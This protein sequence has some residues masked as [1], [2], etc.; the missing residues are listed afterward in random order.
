MSA[1]LYIH[2]PFCAG[3]CSYCSFNSV[4]AE[5]NSPLIKGYFEA[6]A[7]EI[8]RS[9]AGEAAS[10]YFGGGT[11][12]FA[13]ADLLSDTLLAVRK[14]CSVTPEAEITVEVNPGT[15][16]KDFFRKM[17]DAGVNRISLGM[18]SSDDAT[19]KYL[20][21]LH[22][23]SDTENCL[24]E[25]RA[26]G[27]ENIGLDLIYG[28]PGQSLRDIETEAAKLLSLAPQHISTY[29]LSID[30]GTGMFRK[31]EKGE[32]QELSGD[33]AA[34]MYYLLKDKLSVKYSH[35]ELSN[36][37]LP[38]RESR[39]NEIY[40][41]YNDYIGF[42]AG[43]ASKRGSRRMS[44]ESDPVKYMELIKRNDSA[45]LFEENLTEET[46]LKETVF[47]GLRLLRGIDLAGWKTRF[48]KDF[49]FLFEKQFEKLAGLGLLEQKDGFI[50]LTREG[51][52][53]SNEVFVE[54]V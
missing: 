30:E 44:N 12:S 40:W 14:K 15:A 17:K 39:H 47:L 52:F 45:I 41:N 18:Q 23:N 48:G 2:V 29:C 42:G 7:L 20:G 1:G 11:P 49:L 4:P 19:L 31:R 16:G 53:L 46:Q 8:G 3:K 21:R 43:A 54:F 33:L 9:A 24:S 5:K 10:V 35:Y 32:L 6:L 27:I 38:G 37:S 26:A 13:G 50:K 51:L 34:D 28:I 25:A 22:T 36:Y